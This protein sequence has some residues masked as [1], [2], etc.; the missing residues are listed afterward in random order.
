MLHKH[1]TRLLPPD[2]RSPRE[3][4]RASELVELAALARYR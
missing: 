1:Y 4:R 3:S 2:T